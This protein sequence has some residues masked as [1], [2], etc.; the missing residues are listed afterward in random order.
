MKKPETICVQG[1]YRPK[2]GE[3]RVCPV[4]KS[5]TFYYENAQD[6]ADLFDLKSE[7]YFYT[8]LANPTV[9]AFEEKLVML[10]GGTVGIATASGMS[11]PKR[12]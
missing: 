3:A 9:A 2:S 6:M 11:I 12:K 10:D 7:G 5:T 4:V 8:R 1:S